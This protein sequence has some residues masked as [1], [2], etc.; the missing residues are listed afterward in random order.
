MRPYHWLELLCVPVATFW[1]RTNFTHM[2]MARIF[3]GSSD[4]FEDSY[5]PFHHQNHEE[6][7][8]GTLYYDVRYDLP[9]KIIR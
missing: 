5:E 2:A 3:E 7:F 4:H 6:A 9:Q 1:P 8:S